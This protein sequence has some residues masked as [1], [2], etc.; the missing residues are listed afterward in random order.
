MSKIFTYFFVALM[1]GLAWAV[2]GTF[3]HDYGSAWAGAIGGLAVILVAKR[4]DWNKR[5][6]IIASLCGIGWGV[7][8]LISIGQVTG[9][10]NGNDFIN[11]FY[12]FLMLALIG[13]LYGYIGGG[14]MG[15]ALESRENK[16]ADWA[17]LITEM[18]VL[19]F[20]CWGLII[21]EYEWFMTPPRSEIWAGCL[22]ASIALWWFMKRNGYKNSLRV[23]AFSALGAGLGFSCG[24]FLQIVLSIP[25]LH[26]G[27][28]AVTEFSIGFGGGLGMLYGV[29][30]CDW[31]TI[32][33]NKEFKFNNGFATVFLSIAFPFVNI[34]M[35][36]ELKACMENLVN[37]G[38]PDPI[39]IATLCLTIAYIVFI[40]FLVIVYL[41]NKFKDKTSSGINY[42]A[43]YMFMFTILYIVFGNL[44]KSIFFV[45]IGINQM[46][47]WGF[48]LIAGIIYY[49]V[50]KPNK[51]SLFEPKSN[52]T[53][54]VWKNI[55]F[56][57][58]ILFAIFTVIAIYVQI[59]RT[60]APVRY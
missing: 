55:L 3:G 11:V 35:A 6:A 21:H 43:G 56:S 38:H 13:G 9:Y 40:I 58:I 27:W 32:K 53:L 23:A 44:K 22:G 7:G 30:S 54:K 42:V 33:E 25:A 50:V 14:F 10:C 29:L 15:L 26:M 51:V 34:F 46:R 52:N 28:W 1:M 2:R 4:Y 36:M 20:L 12:G 31:P 24:N 17:R 37:Q 45:D 18:T 5:M 39:A 48:L 16:K 49:L 60:G 57:L 8:G 59:G 41:M 47:N 19:G